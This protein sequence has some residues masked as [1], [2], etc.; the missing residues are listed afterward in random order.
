MTGARLNREN[1]LLVVASDDLCLRVVDTQTRRM[2][3]EFHGHT[4]R[5]TDFVSS[6]NGASK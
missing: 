2:V 3:R 5:I 6:I 4:N 1:E